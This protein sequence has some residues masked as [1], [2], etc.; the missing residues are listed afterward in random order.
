[1]TGEST[2]SFIMGIVTFSIIIMI[3][4]PMFF[5]IYV[6]NQNQ[7]NL[8]N[9]KETLKENDLLKDDLKNEKISPTKMM[10]ILTALFT[11]NAD[12]YGLSPLMSQIASLTISVCFYSAIIA[13]ASIYWPLLIIAGIAAFIQSLSIK[14]FFTPGSN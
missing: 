1:M 13:L 9:I 4:T 12:Q 10:K 5:N 8:D 7:K 3:I 11:F 6:I 14:G 2:P